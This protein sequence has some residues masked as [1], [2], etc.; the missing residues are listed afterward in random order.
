MRLSMVL[1]TEQTKLKSSQSFIS[2][3]F[4]NHKK[5]IENLMKQNKLLDDENKKNNNLLKTLQHQLKEESIKR[6]DLEAYGRRTCVEIVGLPYLEN[7][8]CTSLTIAVAE[9]LKMDDFSKDSIDVAHRVSQRSDANIIVKFKDRSARD[10]FFQHRSQ[11]KGLTPHHL[12]VNNTNLFK[13]TNKIFINESLTP[14]KKNLFWKARTKAREVG[15]TGKDKTG[16]CWTKNGLI[17][18]QK[19][20]GE[21]LI[22]VRHESDLDKLK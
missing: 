10:N 22:K 9:M 12:T 15:W 19:S 13:D 21:T 1:R 4:D 11:L 18:A 16:R 7:E 20:T 17:F 5:I 14:S 2:D 8:N 3:Q 6:D